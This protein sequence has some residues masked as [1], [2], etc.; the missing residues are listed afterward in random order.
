[1]FSYGGYTFVVH[2][3]TDLILLNVPIVACLVILHLSLLQRLCLCCIAVGVRLVCLSAVL[4]SRSI[5]ST[6]SRCC[7]CGSSSSRFNAGSFFGMGVLVRLEY[8][9]KFYQMKNFCN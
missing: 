5:T 2:A 6:S 9:C 3:L 7:S 4:W 8:F 1:M